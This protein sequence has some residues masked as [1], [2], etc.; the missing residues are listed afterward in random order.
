MKT[1]LFVSIFFGLL[2]ANTSLCGESLSEREVVREV[3]AANPTL[4]AAAAK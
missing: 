3:L 2:L 4:A 1:H